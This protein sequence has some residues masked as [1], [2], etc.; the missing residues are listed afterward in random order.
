MKTI[1]TRKNNMETLV[2]FCPPKF[3]IANG[4]NTIKLGTLEHYRGQDPN[5]TI[6]DNIKDE[7]EGKESIF[8]H[9]LITGTKSNEAMESIRG[10]F[11]TSPG[12]IIEYCK[13]Y[14]TFPNCFIWCCSKVNKPVVPGQGTNIDPEYTDFYEIFNA[15]GFGEYLAKQLM[16]YI[17]RTPFSKSPFTDAARSN[18]QDL[19]RNQR[20]GRIGIRMFHHDV[21]YVDQRSSIIQ[22][23]QLIHPFD[24]SIPL[25]YRSLFAKKKRYEK[26]REHR[27]V[28]LVQYEREH[29]LQ[30]RNE[31]VYLSIDPASRNLIDQLIIANS[32]E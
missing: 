7:D 10:Y 20:N 24:G 15:D 3:N 16:K 8:V 28:F 4:C 13:V 17:D 31:P 19:A 14:K 21:T 12:N 11:P 1:A 9:R 22:N 30:V 5:F 2:K 27:Y 25:G 32:K 23:D 6:S 26:E 18:L 29:T